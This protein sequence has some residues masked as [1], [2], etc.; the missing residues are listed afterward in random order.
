MFSFNSFTGEVVVSTGAKSLHDKVVDMA[1]TCTSSENGYGE[2]N[3][4]RVSF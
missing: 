4:F 2:T 3:R 1:L